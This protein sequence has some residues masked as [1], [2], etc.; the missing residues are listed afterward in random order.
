MPTVDIDRDTAH[1]LAQSELSKPIYPRAS[2]SDRLTEWLDELLFRIVSKGSQIPGGFFTITLLVILAI[3]AVVVAVRIARKTMRTNRGDDYALF[4]TADLSAEQHRQT[5]EQYAASGDWAAAM[6]HR[7]RAIARQLEET[8]VLTPVPGRTS[9][10][11]AR[12]AGVSMPDLS[13]EF[14]DAATAFN[15]VTFGERPGTEAG[16]RLMCALDDHLRARPRG[17]TDS[18]AA[19]PMDASWAEVG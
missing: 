2:A 18:G 16:Y 3:V 1:D 13:R 17:A 19:T 11:L 15:D 7:L 6:R 5:S 4:G 9:Y 10:E 12:A 8:G 14:L